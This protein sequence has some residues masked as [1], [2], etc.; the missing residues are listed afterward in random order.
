MVHRRLKPLPPEWWTVR[1]IA[2]WCGVTPQ[3]VYAW[4]RTGKV[5]A[6][7]R[8]FG[9]RLRFTRQDVDELLGRMMQHP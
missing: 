8:T 3:A 1:E 2:E 4:V 5:R 6:R 9:G 7:I